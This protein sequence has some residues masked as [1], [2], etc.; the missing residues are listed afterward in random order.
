MRGGSLRGEVAHGGALAVVLAL[1][2]AALLAGCG[3]GSSTNSTAAATTVPSSP[4]ASTQS[5]TSSADAVALVSGTPISKAG[6]EHWLAVEKALGAAS[7]PSHEALA[8]LI[9]SEWVLGEAAA[10]KLSVSEAEVKRRL[11]QTEKQSFPKAGSLAKFLATSGET[12]ADLLARVRVEQLQ[13][14]IVAQIDAGKSAAQRQAVLSAF[15]KAFQRHWKAY[16]TC[17][18]GYVMEDCVEYRGA[19]ENLAAAGSSSRGSASR[20]STGGAA[21]SSAAGASSSSG[22][23]PAPLSGQ[24]SISSSAFERNGEIPAQ[25]T[26]DGANISP[27]LE[28]KNV[29]SKAAALVLFAIDDSTA[30]SAGGIR[31]IVGDIDPSSTGVAAGQTPAGGIVGSDTQGKNG[32]GGICPPHGKTSTIEFVLYALSKKIPLSPGFQPTVAESEYGSGKLLMGQ[33]AVTY[34][35]YHRP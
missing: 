10:R 24:M 34:A 19:S 29:P 15:E 26:C 8:F 13:S 28:W 7:N 27:P 22:E 11:E 31:W 3:G 4:A 18:P 20:S 16:T 17:K 2:L 6:Y 23:L 30:G 5:S 12:E 33:A 25:Y 1:L 35:V 32:Y 9:T 21:R 14:R